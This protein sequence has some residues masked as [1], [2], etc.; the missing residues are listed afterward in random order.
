M[1]IPRLKVP[2]KLM[3][4]YCEVLR[5][6]KDILKETIM[7]VNGTKIDCNAA[8]IKIMSRIS[9]RG[10]LAPLKLIPS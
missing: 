3:V 7:H 10:T 5:P 4:Y 2:I 1:V 9:W 6:I 8:K